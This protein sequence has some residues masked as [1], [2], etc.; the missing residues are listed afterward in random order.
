MFFGFDDDQLAFRDAARD[1]FDK[2]CA[3]AVVRAAWDAPAGALSRDVWDRLAE[4]G[5]LA[6]L[7]PEDDDGL[8][9]DEQALVLVLEEAGRAGLPHPLVDTA[10]VAAPLVASAGGVGTSG[11]GPGPVGIPDAHGLGMVATDLGGPLVACARDADWLLLHDAPRGALHLVDP[12]ATVLAPVATVDGARRAASVDWQPTPETLVTDDPD[13]VAL[14]FDRGAFGTAAVL[15][16]LGQRM[17]DM[18]VAY[19]TQREQFGVPIGSFQAVK[20]HLAD[21]LKEL[22][23]ARPAVYRAA[24]SLATGAGTRG[25][26]VSMAKA[27]ASD[28]AAFVGRQALQCH[29]AIGYTVEH[30]LHLYLKRTWAL[31]AAWGDASWHRERVAQA[32]GI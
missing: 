28:A 5:V 29:G 16:G 25:R 9:L 17:L 11:P 24:H 32:I 12:A 20:H 26:D 13:A 2:E 22:A 14:A 21:A 23:F 7:V 1:L 6:T 15:V 31:A 3:P 4:M 8:G 18:S 19:V 10:T 30:D 27:M